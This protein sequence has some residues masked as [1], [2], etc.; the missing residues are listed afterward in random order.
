[1]P[2]YEGRGAISRPSVPQIDLICFEANPDGPF[3]YLL[4]YEDHAIKFIDCAP[5]ESK[6]H[7]A[8]ALNL[9]AVLHAPAVRAWRAVA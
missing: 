2:Y 7:S 6:R 8:V 5:L 9:F 3:K 4:T 1:M